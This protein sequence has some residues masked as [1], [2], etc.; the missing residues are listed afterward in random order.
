L[1]QIGECAFSG[2]GLISIV[3]P[4]SIV[5]LTKE[6][7]YECESLESVRFEDGSRLE[8]IEERAFAR[9]GLKS[10]EIPSSVVV[11]GRE[12][13]RS[14]KLLKS[15]AFGIGCRLERIDRW[16]FK[17]SS[18]RFGSISQKLARAKVE[19]QKKVVCLA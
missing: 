11:L 5:F 3:I 17:D 6:L 8:W 13:F 15:V 12:S 7:F 4:P 19:N 18:V 14:C 1:E 10:I 2:S 16:M 9:S